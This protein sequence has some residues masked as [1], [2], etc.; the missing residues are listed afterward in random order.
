[1]EIGR[2][3]PMSTKAQKHR[4]GLYLMSKDRQFFSVPETKQ[5]KEEQQTNSQKGGKWENVVSESNGTVLE[6]RLM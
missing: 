4:L 2:G 6:R 1:M 3:N 5:W